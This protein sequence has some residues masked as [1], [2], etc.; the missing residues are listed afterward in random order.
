MTNEILPQIDFSTFIISLSSS[1]LMYMGEVEGHSDTIDL[2]LAKQTIEIIEMLQEKT[3][4]NLDE[5][6]RILLEKML[7]D[8]RLRY[9]KAKNA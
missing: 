3:K 9:V 1:A 7:Y 8:L 4:N 2:P 5:Q 6:E